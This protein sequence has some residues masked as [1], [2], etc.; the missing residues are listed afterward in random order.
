MLGK[1]MIAGRGE[2]VTRSRTAGTDA[3]S[4]T[5]QSR[6]DPS[7]ALKLQQLLP[8]RFA[9]ELEL[10]CKTRDGR[11]AFFFQDDENR[12]P[13]IWKLIDGDDVRT[14]WDPEEPR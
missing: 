11:R 2:L 1:K 14:P 10:L 12:P 5:R 3:I 13:A 6:F 7:L 4:G 8:Y 9:G